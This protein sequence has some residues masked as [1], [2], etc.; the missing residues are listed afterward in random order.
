[1]LRVENIRRDAVKK[2]K[3]PLDSFESERMRPSLLLEAVRRVGIV[4]DRIVSLRSE[5]CVLS[6][7]FFTKDAPFFV[8]P[9][10]IVPRGVPLALAAWLLEDFDPSKIMSSDAHSPRRIP[11]TGGVLNRDTHRERQSYIVLAEL[12][13]CW[14]NGK[15]VRGNG[16]EGTLTFVNDFRLGEAHGSTGR[17][18]G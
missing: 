9:E 1:M 3:P 16:A 14:G 17:R 13:S 10:T 2:P 6:T 8:I 15:W 5:R 18:G 11:E 12:G 4:L 7:I